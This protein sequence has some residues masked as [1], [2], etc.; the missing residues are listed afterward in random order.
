VLAVGDDELDDDEALSELG[1]VTR[2]SLKMGRVD[3]AGDRNL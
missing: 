1:K 2:M 3:I